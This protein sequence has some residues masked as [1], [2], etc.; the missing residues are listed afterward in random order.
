MGFWN[1]KLFGTA[2]AGLITAFCTAGI[3]RWG[4]LV[5]KCNESKSWQTFS[6]W[7]FNVYNIALGGGWFI[8]RRKNEDNSELIA[9]LSFALA[10]L[11]S[12]GLI[13]SLMFI[14]G[15]RRNRLRLVAPLVYLTAAGIV[16]TAITAL[17]SYTAN[18]MIAPT[19]VHAALEFLIHLKWT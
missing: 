9:P 12:I 2:V 14:C 19:V 8:N 18:L 3:L 1:V 10:L 13:A 7:V 6:D 15:L 4:V 11:T 16:F 5:Y 17:C